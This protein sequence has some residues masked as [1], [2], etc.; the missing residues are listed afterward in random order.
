MAHLSREVHAIRVDAAQRILVWRDRHCH[1]FDRTCASRDADP[2]SLGAV[3][4]GHDLVR[5]PTHH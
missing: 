4:L 1:S 5:W 3:D 2:Q